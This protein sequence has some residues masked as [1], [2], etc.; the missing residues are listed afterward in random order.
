VRD[1]VPANGMQGRAGEERP[2]AKP[3]WL[4]DAKI[5]ALGSAPSFAQNAEV[6][7]R[8]ENPTD[9]P[10][11]IGS[12]Q[13]EGAAALVHEGGARARI[14]AISVGVAKPLIVPPRGAKEASLLFEAARGTPQ[15]L[16]LYDKEFEIPHG[17]PPSRRRTVPSTPQ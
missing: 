5:H 6:F 11:V 15:K 7:L 9:Q 14:H 12:L 2:R 16:E 3:S 1:R 17:V 10:L 13:S 4:Q 8:I